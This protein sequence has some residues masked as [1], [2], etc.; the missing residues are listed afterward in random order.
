M[1]IEFPHSPPQGYSYEYEEFKRNIYSIWIRN[2]T[3]FDYNGGDPVRS[4]WGF[5]NTRTKTYH[6]PINSSTVGHAVDIERTTPYSAMI[7]KQTPLE[8]AYV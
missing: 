1:I 5:Y 3:R 2:H 7:P 6:M 8:A 4:I